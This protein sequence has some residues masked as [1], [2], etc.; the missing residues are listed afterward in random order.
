M[1]GL[2]VGVMGRPAL[3]LEG[4]DAALLKDINPGFGSSLPSRFYEFNGSML[5]LASSGET[6]GVYK[7]DG[8]EAG[9]VLV[10][11]LY[12]GATNA[13]GFTRVGDTLFFVGDDGTTGLELWKT[14]GTEAGTVLVK[15]VDP[16]SSPF[17]DS[18]NGSDPANFVALGDTLLFTA[19]DANGVELW[20]SDGTPEGT[21]MVKDINPDE[22]INF[23]RSSPSGLTA[24]GD[25]VVFTALE[26]TSGREPWVSDGTPE[27]TV[28]LKDI[29]P[30]G[31][32]T[33]DSTTFAPLGGVVFFKAISDIYGAELWKTDG[34]ADGTVIVKDI[35]EGV[36]DGTP[37]GN[38]D[39]MKAW[40]GSVYFAGD[41]GT[42]GE[43]LWKTDGTADGTVL[44]K[45]TVPGTVGGAPKWFTPLGDIM[46]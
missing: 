11:S 26:P 16:G 35:N 23:G 27:G 2:L 32:S 43:E 4:E 39:S 46:L 20:K 14:D 44:V 33:T 9:T 8:T 25:K 5:F 42:T 10:K 34:T 41:D 13:Q 12:P 22:A 21:V 7:T 18:P 1:G 36:S 6:P 3:G 38:A 45:D 28:L 17:D 31:D 15:D 24:V 37:F 19:N 30:A 29:N 40:N